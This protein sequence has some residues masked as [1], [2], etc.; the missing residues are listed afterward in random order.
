MNENTTIRE[1]TQAMGMTYRVRREAQS[2]P[3]KRIFLAQRT[4]SGGTVVTINGKSYQE[5]K[6][7]AA[8]KL[9]KRVTVVRKK[10]GI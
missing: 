8:K 2:S 1:Q 9:G 6:K 3:I 5:A 10:S 7:A 4:P